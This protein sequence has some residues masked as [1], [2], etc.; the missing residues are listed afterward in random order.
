MAERRILLE[1]HRNEV[2]AQLDEL[3]HN[4]SEIEQKIQHHKTLKSNNDVN[5]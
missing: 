1:A 2:Q 3:Q 4:L 5:I